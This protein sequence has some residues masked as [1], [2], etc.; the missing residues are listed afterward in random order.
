M[1]KVGESEESGANSKPGGAAVSGGDT[2]NS[3]SAAAYEAGAGGRHGARTTARERVAGWR[4]N[5]A[6]KYYG[7]GGGGEICEASG[8]ASKTYGVRGDGGGRKAYGVAE[9]PGGDRQGVG[10]GVE[11][12]QGINTPGV[13]ALPRGDETPGVAT[14]GN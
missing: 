4:E 9:N 10:G 2:G 11:S 13:D 12:P 1:A 14:K 3:T 6:G 8:V 5:M 7:V